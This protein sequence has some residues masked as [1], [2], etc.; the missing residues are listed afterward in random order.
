MD[1]FFCPLS[2][3][4]VGKFLFIGAWFWY[5]DSRTPH[6][7]RQGKQTF[8]AVDS[9]ISSSCH[10]PFIATPLDS[11]N[12]L[13]LWTLNIG[14]RPRHPNKFYIGP[15]S[16]HH[17]HQ[18]ATL[19]IIPLNTQLSSFLYK[20]VFPTRLISLRTETTTDSSLCA[21]RWFAQFIIHMSNNG[22]RQR[23]SSLL[24][25]SLKKSLLGHLGRSVG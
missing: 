19:F 20:F 7:I 21:S 15:V 9:S 1:C 4:I 14:N 3:W 18:T 6:V 12:P 23:V 2:P 22:H 25:G 24:P 10:K 11:M 13:C 17:S 8:L 16:L 5:P